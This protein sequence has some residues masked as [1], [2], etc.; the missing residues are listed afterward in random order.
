M[1][2]QELRIWFFDMLYSCYPVKHDDYP[3][4]VFWFYDDKFIRKI[5]LCKLSGNS[6]KLPSKVKGKCLFEQNIKSRYLWCDFDEIW[7]VFYKEYKN[8]YN[9][10]QSLIKSWL[11]E[12]SKLNVFT[13]PVAESFG[14][15]LLEEESKLNVFTPYKWKSINDARLEEESKLNVFTPIRQSFN[16]FV[17]LEEESKLNV[18][19]PEISMQLPK[20]G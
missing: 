14:S 1:S 15:R 10:V 9:D 5:K 2:E 11:E 12:E 19:T 7:S 8:N 16:G 17:L 13:P 6:I 4:S 3:N 20:F 18:F